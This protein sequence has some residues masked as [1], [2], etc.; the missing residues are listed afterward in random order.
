MSPVLWALILIKANSV[1]GAHVLNCPKNEIK[2]E[3]IIGLPPINATQLLFQLKPNETGRPITLDCLAMCQSNEACQSFVLYYDNLQCYWFEYDATNST[4]DTR[5]MVDNDAAWFVKSCLKTECNK[6]WVFEAV[7]GATLVG[8]DTRILGIQNI[9]RRECEQKCLEERGFQCRSIKF[10]ISFNYMTQH[11]NEA[12]GKCTLSSA[13]RHL[14]PMAYRVS[15]N[16]DYYLEHQGG[17][18]TK[19]AF[20]NEGY[21]SYE[22]YEDVVQ[23]HGDV[24]YEK[25]SKEDCQKQCDIYEGFNCRGFSVISNLQLC[26]LHSEDTK[27]RGPRILAPHKGGFYYEKARC[28]NITVSCSQSYMTVRYQPEI[29]FRGKLYMQR[30]SENPAC[31]VVGQGKY[32]M[33]TL[34]LQLLTSQCGIVKADS[35]TNR[36]LMSG[37][38]ILQYNPL[39]QTQSDRIMRVGCIFGNESKILLGTGIN[40]TSNLPNKGSPLINTTSNATVAPVVEMK[41]VD[42]KT[43]DETSDTQ[44]GQE[45]Q[46]IIELKETA[47]TYDIWAGHLIAMT[48][49]GDESI[50]LLDDRGCPTNLNIFPMLQKI[51]TTT[52]KKLMATFQAFKFANSPVVRFSVIVQFCPKECI[53]IQCE[54]NAQSYGRKRREIESHL[55]ETINGTQRIQAQTQQNF[56]KIIKQRTT[57]S[58]VVNQMPLEYVMVVRDSNTRPDRLILGNKDGKILVAGYNYTTNEVCMDFSLVIGLIVTWII[59][60]LIFIIACLSLIRR[61]K[62]HYKE[63]YSRASLEELHKNFGLGFSNLENRRVRWADNGEDLL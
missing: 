38:L 57:Q 32:T 17:D 29:D 56:L 51:S 49:K 18:S 26:I 31:F 37:T 4:K 11:H 52:G 35:P 58:S 8:N 39:I 48:E 21:C 50:F 59:V 44:I 19:R 2:F 45:L 23:L 6:L 9:S 25:M 24:L 47:G 36:T 43:Q 34:K 27:L 7:R 16:D 61:Y 41:V 1:L 22:E 55:L 40:I 33:V 13:D 60:Q 62:N 46:L 12:V 30:N 53:P 42:L 63:E 20:D 15:T 10:K 3:K 5:L 14:N 28:L 54:N